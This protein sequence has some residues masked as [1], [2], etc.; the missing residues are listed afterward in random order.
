MVLQVKIRVRGGG[1]P[2]FFIFCLNLLE[3]IRPVLESS[4]LFFRDLT[5]ILISGS[6]L[7]YLFWVKIA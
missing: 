2:Q 3:K 5:A 6:G 1:V 4:T 7:I